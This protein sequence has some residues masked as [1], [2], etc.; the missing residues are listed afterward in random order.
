MAGLGQVTGVAAGL[1]ELTSRDP[2]AEHHEVRH[3]DFDAGPSGQSAGEIEAADGSEERRQ[4]PVRYLNARQPALP[5]FPEL[6]RRPRLR[7]P[8]SPESRPRLR[9]PEKASPSLHGGSR[10]A[11]AEE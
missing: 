4:E 10:C 3:G 1:R 8:T 9:S 6:V 11:M 2:F 7:A 5:M